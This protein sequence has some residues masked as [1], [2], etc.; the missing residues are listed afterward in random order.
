MAFLLGK[1]PLQ[2]KYLFSNQK[3]EC[4]YKQVYR[5]IGLDFYPFLSYLVRKTS[6]FFSAHGFYS[7]DSTSVF[8]QQVYE[9][10]FGCALEAGAAAG[11]RVRFG[12]WVVPLQGAA[13]CLAV[14]A[15]ECGCRCRR[16]PRCT[17]IIFFDHTTPSVV[18]LQT[19]C[20]DPKPRSASPGGGAHQHGKE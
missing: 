9:E 18:A 2:T 7:A 10:V 20:A 15:C 5:L 6:E 4:F 12:A 8:W 17:G 1:E 19:R 11:C 16:V 3:A 14:C 13:R